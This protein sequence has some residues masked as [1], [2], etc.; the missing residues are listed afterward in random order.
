MSIPNRDFHHGLL[1]GQ[2]VTRRAAARLDASAVGV[3]PLSGDLVLAPRVQPEP[4]HGGRTGLGRQ[5]LG[6]VSVAR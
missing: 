4:V 6:A 5:R 1:G 3:T 2:R